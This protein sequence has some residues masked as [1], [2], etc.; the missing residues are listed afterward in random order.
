MTYRRGKLT[1]SLRA[2]KSYRTGEVAAEV[3][4]V[5]FETWDFIIAADALSSDD[6]ASAAQ[7]LEP[8]VGD[9]IVD[10]DNVTYQV[11]PLPGQKHFQYHGGRDVLR[12]HTKLI[13]AEQEEESGG[14]GS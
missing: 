5:N 12:V 4:A 11:A 10:A 1:I 2:V 13:G 9:L 7:L 14:S 6:S 3:S 8:E